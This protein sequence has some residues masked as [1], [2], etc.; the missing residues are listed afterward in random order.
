MNAAV[1]WRV[2][3]RLLQRE[4]GQWVLYA[5]QFGKIIGELRA[6]FRIAMQ[7]STREITMLHP[8]VWATSAESNRRTPT[9]R[10]A[11]IWWMLQALLTAATWA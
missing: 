11:R 2:I 3:V 8:S 6:P 4:S 9:V 7:Q 5:L 1:D 10:D